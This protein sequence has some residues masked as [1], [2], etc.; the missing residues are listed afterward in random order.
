MKCS[1]FKMTTFDMELCYM[2]PWISHCEV[3]AK[4]LDYMV[5]VCTVCCRRWIRICRP[6]PAAWGLKGKQNVAF[7]CG[8]TYDDIK[9]D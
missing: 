6:V 1:M 8:L 9:H 7:C 2:S 5:L 3:L 4:W